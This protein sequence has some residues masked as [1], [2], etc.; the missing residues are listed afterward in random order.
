MT[1]VLM[2]PPPAWTRLQYLHVEPPWG[3]REAWLKSRG[4]RSNIVTTAPGDVLARVTYVCYIQLTIAKPCEA[5]GKVGITT[6]L[7]AHSQRERRSTRDLRSWRRSL[8]M[9][10]S[11]RKEQRPRPPVQLLDEGKENHSTVTVQYRVSGRRYRIV[12]S[13]A[14]HF[15]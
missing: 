14:W 9:S 7:L 5:H 10:T 4:G 15:G 6:I 2:D 13:T 3:S 1:S 11:G 8:S 12:R